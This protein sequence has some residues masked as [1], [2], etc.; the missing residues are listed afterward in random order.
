MSTKL[1]PV[2][3]VYFPLVAARGFPVRAALRHANVDFNFKKVT[4]KEFDAEYKSDAKKAPLAAL[5]VLEL[6]QGTFGKP[7]T[8]YVQ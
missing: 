1:A 6:P 5:P 7:M 2:S 3:V 4:F 8:I